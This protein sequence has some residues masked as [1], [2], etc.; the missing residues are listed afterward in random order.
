MKGEWGD[1]GEEIG[2]VDGKRMEMRA[3]LYGGN[4]IPNCVNVLII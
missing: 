2:R 3:Y 1:G 4:E